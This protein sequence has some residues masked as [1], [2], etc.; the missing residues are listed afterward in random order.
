MA[1]FSLPDMACIHVINSFMTRFTI[2]CVLILLYYSIPV[3]MARLVS[4]LGHD[5]SSWQLLMKV[6]IHL[7]LVNCL[8][9]K[10]PITI[11]RVFSEVLVAFL[12]FDICHYVWQISK[13]GKAT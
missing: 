2:Y 9:L 11:V 13:Y 1:L 4:T 12:Y 8:T 3:R 5:R 10:A 6:F 7:V